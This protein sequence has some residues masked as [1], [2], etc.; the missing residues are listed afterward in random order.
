MDDIS[1]RGLPDTRICGSIKVYRTY[2]KRSGEEPRQDTW[3]GK[4]A[5]W[6]SDTGCKPRLLCEPH[7]DSNART[8]VWRVFSWTIRIH[9]GGS[10]NF[11]NPD[12]GHRTSRSV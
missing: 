12:T 11:E 2:E 8:N 10:E 9:H 4:R 5:R 6:L 1:E 7:K 3:E